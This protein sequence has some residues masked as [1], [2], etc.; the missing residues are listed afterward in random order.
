MIDRLR[1][2]VLVDNA[3]VDER[4]QAEH[5]LSFWIEA[6][7]R[8]ILFDVGA[9][10]ALLR[11][12]L[13]LDV[14]LDE[15]DEIVLSHGHFDHTGGLAAVLKT[16]GKRDVYLHP[17]AL[18]NKFAR[19][20]SPPHRDIG[21]SKTGDGRFDESI[22]RNWARRFVCTPL[23]T[24]LSTGIGL[25]GQ[26]PRCN[27]FEDVGG[28]FY[29][30]ESCSDPDLLLDDQ[31]MFVETCEGTVVILGCAHSGVVNT[32]DYVAK[33]TGRDEIFA[34]VG[35]MHLLRAG[36]SRLDATID[37]LRR[38]GVAYVGPAHCTGVDATRRLREAFSD[39]FLKCRAGATLG[40]AFAVPDE[41][42]E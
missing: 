12:A 18:Q 9:S 20:K 8:R 25:T 16:V 33:L 17:A 34:V 42:R 29:L 41:E 7:R 38:Y 11:N 1:I 39:G 40:F 27:D 13:Q 5:G 22:L 14:P 32:L 21:I 35:G 30:D 23:P 37:A 36:N 19:E 4:L 26:I 28:P 2:T 31:A 10:N 15:V 24:M 3:A 6:D